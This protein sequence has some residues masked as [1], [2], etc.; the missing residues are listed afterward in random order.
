LKI[1]SYYFRKELHSIKAAIYWIPSS[2]F[3]FHPEQRV[4]RHV[5]KLVRNCNSRQLYIRLHVV[6]LTC[7]FEVTFEILASGK[8]D[9]EMRHGYPIS[10]SRCQSVSGRYNVFDLKHK[11]NQF[12]NPMNNLSG[13]R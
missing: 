6:N 5:G 13:D 12:E 9:L 10:L 7:P 3:H 2:S 4:Y 8:S 11:I 1:V